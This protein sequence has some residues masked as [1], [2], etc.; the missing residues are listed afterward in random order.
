LY[1][2][3]DAFKKGYQPRTNT[4]RDE[5]CDLVTHSH[6]IFA[7]C[8]N[9]T[10]IHAAEPLVQEPIAFE[11]ELAIEKLK[12]HKSPHTDQIPA[13][14]IKAGG[15]TVQYETRTLIHYIWDKEELP[16]EH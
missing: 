9:Q 15:R 3:T 12:S 4:V 13:E 2:G 16:K 5:N 1:G 10:E 14:P 7:R 6:S 11:S 8:R